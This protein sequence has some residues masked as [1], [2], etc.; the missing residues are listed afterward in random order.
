IGQSYIRAVLLMPDEMLRPLPRPCP[1]PGALPR[2]CSTPAPVQE[3]AAPPPAGAASPQR[4]HSGP[5]TASLNR[6]ALKDYREIPRVDDASAPPAKLD[7]DRLRRAPEPAAR[8]APFR[9]SIDF[10][11]RP[12]WAESWG[13][14]DSRKSCRNG[15]ASKRQCPSAGRQAAG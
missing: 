13:C 6:D 5:A 3:P 7:A 8:G 11:T 4:P 1:A 14:G 9:R 10:Q 2:S 12:A 15:I